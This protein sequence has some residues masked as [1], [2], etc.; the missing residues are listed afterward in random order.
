MK[1]FL[2]AFLGLALCGGAFAVAAAVAEKLNATRSSRLRRR[3][4]ECG[5]YPVHG[6]FPAVCSNCVDTSQWK[7]GE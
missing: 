6:S 5:H 4:Q 2:S 1:L 7:A 3:C